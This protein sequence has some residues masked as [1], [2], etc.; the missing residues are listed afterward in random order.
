MCECIKNID[1][2]PDACGL[3]GG[4]GD[5][6]W[7]RS[8]RKLD[9]ARI[10][11]MREICEDD[12]DEHP[13]YLI[14]MS[15]SA[16][17]KLV[18][19]YL[20]VKS[21]C[22]LDSVICKKYTLM[23]W[24]EALRGTYSKDLSAWPRNTNV[25]GFACLKWCI[26]RRVE[27]RDVKIWRVVVEG[28]VLTDKAHIFEWLCQPKGEKK[29]KQEFNNGNIACLLAEIG[30]I[31]SNIEC[32]KRGQSAPILCLASLYGRID[33]VTTLL[34]RGT[35]INKARDGGYTPLFMASQQGHMEVVRVLVEIGADIDKADN[36]GETPL[37]SAQAYYRTEIIRWS[38]PVPSKHSVETSC[39][40]LACISQHSSLNKSKLPLYNKGNNNRYNK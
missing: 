13:D 3:F 18:I 8:Q 25:D 9:S 26:Q 34:E 5:P 10:R 27:V 4:V 1:I 20:D 29:T 7:E 16:A 24:H 36:D 38:V 6:V 19:E 33:I 39:F 2:D 23:A 35:A 37:R 15:E 30:W 21:L 12:P 40:V 11:Q 28:V 22:R 32:K 31:D 17:R 14:C